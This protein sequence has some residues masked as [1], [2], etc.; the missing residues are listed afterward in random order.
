MRQFKLLLAATAVFILSSAPAYAQKFNRAKG[1]SAPVMEKRIEWVTTSPGISEQIIQHTGFVVS[2]NENLLIPNWVC[3]ELTP[4]EA[5][6]KL[7]LRTETVKPD[8]MVKG[9]SARDADY[10]DSGYD[11][12][13]MAPPADMK[14][15]EKAMV[16]SFYFSNV[17]PMKKD[18][19]EGKWFELEQKCRYWAKKYKTSVYIACGPLFVR[20]EGYVIGENEVVVPDAFFKC[21]CQERDGQW[22]ATGFVFPNTKLGSELKN[23]AKPFA[24]VEYL[25][26]YKFFTN[27]P[28]TLHDELGLSINA[29][30]WDIPGWKTQ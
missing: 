26:G 23:L 10:S 25:T 24:V 6:G 19:N 13:F 29:D 18:L 20:D 16:E 12:G 22:V 4:E 11:K 14:W 17:C 8:P 3:W 5:A 9:A 28:G 7:T 27:L 2:Y 15:S 21:V 1:G 30:D